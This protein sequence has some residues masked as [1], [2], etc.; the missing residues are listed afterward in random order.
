VPISAESEALLK[1]KTIKKKKEEDED[2]E[3]PF[4]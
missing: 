2:E 3:M 4:D 1:G